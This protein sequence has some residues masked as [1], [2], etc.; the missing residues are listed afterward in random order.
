MPRTVVEQ[1]VDPMLS[2]VMADVQQ[3]LR[4]VS[5][6][7]D[8]RRLAA[9]ALQAALGACG[10][11]DGLVVGETEVLATT[12]TPTTALHAAARAACDSGRPA[13]R[14][15]VGGRTVLA[16]PVRAGARSVG[17]I[18]V[19]GD[20]ARLDPTVLALVADAIAAGLAA[21]P[22]VEPRAPELLDA[23]VALHGHEDPLAGAV[24]ALAELFGATAGCAL[25]PQADGRLR[26]A[27]AQHLPATT[28]QAAFDAPTL[29]DLLTTSTIVVAPPRSPAA[30]VLTDGIEALAVIPLGRGSGVVLALLPHE[31][32]PPASA[33]LAAFG[34]MVGAAHATAELRRR[35]LG[36]DDVLGA[37]AAAIPN[38]VVVTA[39]DGT[40]LHA[41]APATRLRHRVDAP[42]GAEVPVVGD[43]GVD[44]LFRVA[45]S[46][47]PGTAEVVVLEDV[48]AARE[49]E[50]IKA[51]L[52]AA[53]GHELRTPLTVV[54]GGVRT[55][56]KRGTGITDE[57]LTETLDAMTRNVARLER[58]IEDLL[59]VSAVSDGRHA[60]AP[61]GADLGAVVDELGGGRV[62]VLRPP[63]PI[64]LSFDVAHVRRALNHLVDNA[65]KH[66]EGDVVVE[67]VVRG[68][69]VEVGVV[70]HGPGI[71][72][73]DL[74]RLFNRFQQLDNS[75]TRPV[76]GA[77]LGLYIARRIVEAHGGR[78]WATSRLGRGSRFAF[79][80]PR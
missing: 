8:P 78:I 74:P 69:E 68:D 31:P 2:V 56:A 62:T 10:V 38:P 27:A 54:R 71:F 75:S 43:D 48:T 17:A 28:L 53:I 63:H 18:A 4:A 29:R 32:D 76:D 61:T 41:N 12:G 66:T 5:G 79:T 16:A 3:L 33:L 47:V 36:A 59:F 65:L 25:V 30:R 13:R 72:S 39:T 57:A 26:L 49:V 11:H 58:L 35:L 60:I 37:L 14:A 64:G 9:R 50:R 21:R 45:R 46:T 22:R 19:A 40:V 20:H 55:I 51:D 67:V 15:D 73:G 70:D 42:D 6:G 44:R 23:V 80:L 1:V 77:G 7:A 52:V 24:D 34:R